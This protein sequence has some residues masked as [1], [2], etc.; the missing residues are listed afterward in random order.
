MAQLL[1]LLAKSV[2]WPEEEKKNSKQQ[3]HCQSKIPEKHVDRKQNQTN[4]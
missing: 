2:N 3:R 1:F 4:Y